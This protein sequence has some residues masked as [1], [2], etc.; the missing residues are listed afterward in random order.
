MLTFHKPM[1]FILPAVLI[2]TCSGYLVLADIVMQASVDT[3][4]LPPSDGPFRVYFQLVNTGTNTTGAV[5]NSIIIDQFDLSGGNI[6]PGNP[7]V[8][9]GASGN[10]A[11]PT[12]R[13]ELLDSSFFNSFSQPFVPGAALSF[14]ART[15]AIASSRGPDA[16]SFSI[17]GTNGLPIPTDSKV[18]VLIRMDLD[19]NRPALKVF[20]SDL[21]NATFN[22]PQPTIHL[23]NESKP[24]QFKLA[25][26]ANPGT[27][28]DLLLDF[29]KAKFADL[30]EL[31][32]SVDLRTWTNLGPRAY[33]GQPLIF[34][35]PDRTNYPIRFYRAKL[36][37]AP[38]PT[39]SIPLITGQPSSR[40]NL[41]GTVATF[42]VGA[43]GVMPL[44]YKWRKEGVDLADG[45][46]IFGA[47]NATLTI[48][49]AW[50]SN[51]GVYEVV[52]I[53]AYGA[54]TSQ[55]ALLTITTNE[56]L[57]GLL[58]WLPFDG[59][60]LDAS[61]NNRH[62][63]NVGAIFTTNRQG[64]ANSAAL[65]NVTSYIHVNN[66]DPDQQTNGF[67]FGGWVCPQGGGGWLNWHY[68][69]GWGSTFIQSEPALHFRVGTGSPSTDHGNAAG[70]P[71]LNQ[72]THFFITHS[73][74][75]DS[76]YLNG[77]L[78]GQWP[79][80]PMA[81]NVDYL[82]V[83]QGSDFGGFSGA[84]DD[85]VVYGRELS[86][87]DVARLFTN[88]IS[89]VTIIPPEIVLQPQSR[90]NLLGSTVNFT[91]N[92][93]GMPPLQYQ[94]R[95]GGVN[96]S[97]G[98]NIFGVTSTSL[99]LTNVQLTDGGSYTVV[100]SNN[101]GS[102]TSQVA[103]LSVQT[104]SL[105]L[106]LLAYFPFNGNANDT[107]GNER[108]GVIQGAVLTTNRFGQTDSAYLFNGVNYIQVGNLD[109]DDNT[110]GFSFGAWIR[111]DAFTGVM[112]WTYDAGWGSTY[113]RAGGSS[114][115][116]RVGTGNPSTDHSVNSVSVPL[117]EWTHLFITHNPTNDSLYVNGQFV[118]QW[119]SYPMQGNVAT[120]LIGASYAGNFNGAI[121]EVVVYGRELSNIEVNRLI[122]GGLSEPT[123]IIIGAPI[124]SPSNISLN[125]SGS[126]GS[127]WNVE[128]AIDLRGP[129]T[130]L[131]S[132]LIGTNGVGLF[133]D[134]N[135]PPSAG[136]YR[137]RRQ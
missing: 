10:L 134:T 101:Y 3:S 46:T 79:S 133:Q 72:W 97:N 40:T 19:E 102:V 59:D 95:K 61:G 24:P 125:F 16:F 51:S 117:H 128:R 13:I 33:V 17:L 42:S 122:S 135:P 137:A 78:V 71:P 44:S 56:L 119:V 21:S 37:N 110:N 123:A 112:G 64:V 130:N 107:S 96:L 109:P 45:G 48:A 86:S 120:L 28:G 11:S 47:T 38:Q 93:R 116:F 53:N 113:L 6:S 90:T 80:Y 131:G 129:W 49:P 92:A 103:M 41:V 126:L 82:R 67:S 2:F 114:I 68:D 62:G 1:R 84:L 63:A 136:F 14:T 55:V 15:T 121:D 132:L 124:V 100:V 54:T 52:V 12:G 8:Y 43:S 104:N 83:G 69:G 85:V 94:W 23:T 98:G 57:N 27:N 50:Y 34:S 115:D 31:E 7:T 32:A 20:Q 87:N 89:V 106:G 35:D 81:G 39:Q 26:T 74:V 4:H 99:T 25:V 73:S 9:G 127:S 88:G 18:D 75:L 65:F 5:E 66:L 70:P 29:P 111:P 36:L 77:Q 22:I 58:A 30:F 60:T 108:H 76:L 105:A 118:N 91:L